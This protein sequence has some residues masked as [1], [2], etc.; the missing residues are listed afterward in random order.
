MDQSSTR[1]RSVLQ[2]DP[3]GPLE[4]EALRAN[5]TTAAG[6][7]RAWSHSGAGLAS[8]AHVR[9]QGYLDLGFVYDTETGSN[10]DR[11]WWQRIMTGSPATARSTWFACSKVDRYCT[12]TCC[13]A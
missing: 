9:R 4:G 12:A 11:D 2:R 3:D 1:G 6:E 7:P 8:A 10:H 13:P 5:Q